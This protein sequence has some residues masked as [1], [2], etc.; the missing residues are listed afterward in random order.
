MKEKSARLDDWRFVLPA[1]VM[2][3][4]AKN[5]LIGGQSDFKKQDKAYLCPSGYAIIRKM[6]KQDRRAAQWNTIC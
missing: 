1:M 2:S 5:R 3:D 4:F 6:E